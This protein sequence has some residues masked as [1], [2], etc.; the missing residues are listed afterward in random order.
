MAM[1][2]KQDTKSKDT[3]T[4]PLDWV[5]RVLAEAKGEVPRALMRM[6][7]KALEETVK[8]KRLIMKY[9]K[10]FSYKD[11]ILM[12]NTKIDLKKLNE[13]QENLEK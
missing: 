1:K 13:L 3:I 10:R 11:W 6:S 8:R 4:T 9:Y 12:E 5:A 2:D 7:D